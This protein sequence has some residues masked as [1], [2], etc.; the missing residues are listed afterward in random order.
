MKI[1]KYLGV[2]L[3]TMV[4]AS[5]VGCTDSTFD[6]SMD[7]AKISLASKEYDKASALLELA[8]QEKKNDEEAKSLKDQ[9]DELIN[10]QE[11]IELGK[12]EDASD[13]CSELEARNDINDIISK[14]MDAISEDIL[15]KSSEAANAAF[16]QELQGAE[17]LVN[18]KKYEEAKELLEELSQNITDTTTYMESVNKINS[19]L[20]KCEKG[21]KEKAESKKETNNKPANTETRQAMHIREALEILDSKL[22]TRMNFSF[23]EGPHDYYI[24]NPTDAE[25]IY[26]VNKYTGE[27]YEQRSEGDVVK[28]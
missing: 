8:L 16:K 19:L 25:G 27:A 3:A 23:D 21:I 12:F 1:K 14:Q 9:V 2:V 17:E 6:K 22:E 28:L 5:M 10:I 24:F 7:A 15:A 20:E 11:L 4:I 18:N 13:L 26:Y